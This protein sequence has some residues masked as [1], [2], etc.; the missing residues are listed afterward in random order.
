MLP[1]VR[2][3]SRRFSILLSAGDI[4]HSSILLPIKAKG[5]LAIY[6]G[7]VKSTITITPILIHP[8]LGTLLLSKKK[9]FRRIAKEF[10]QFSPREF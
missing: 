8:I 6:R 4:G 7:S 1:Y 5:W 3:V 2:Q 9:T 10:Q